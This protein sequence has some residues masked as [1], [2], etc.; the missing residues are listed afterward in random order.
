L[1]LIPMVVEQSNR[2]ERAYDIYSRLLKDNIIFLG[3]PIDD[4]VA[5]VVT[6]QLLFLEAEDPEK[7]IH[8]YINSPG[9]SG[10]ASDIV[11]N[12]LRKAAEKKPVVISMGDVAASGGYWVA[13][14]G[15]EVFVQPTTV[16]GSIG[17]IGAWA[18]DDGIGE[19]LGLTYDFVKAGESADL[20]SWLRLPFVG[21]VVPHRP[22]TDDERARVLAEVGRAYNGFVAKVAKGRKMSE[23]KVESLAKGRVWTGV[24][25]VENGLVDRI[26]G[27]D[28]ALRAARER[29][30]IGE[31]EEV[32]LIDDSIVGLFDVGA[33]TLGFSA[34]RP[35]GSL[36]AP[37][38]FAL[39]R[40]AQDCEELT[41]PCPDAV[42][43]GCNNNACADNDQHGCAARCADRC[44]CERG[45]GGHRDA[46]AA[47]PDARFR[48]SRST[49]DAHDQRH[50]VLERD[51]HSDRGRHGG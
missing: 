27:L 24:Q 7:D 21:G 13:I 38:S 32:E 10:M 41:D 34:E 40:Q 36:I 51:V 2:G 22:M 23:E 35:D 17:V 12:A 37:A 9:G 4:N 19:K 29:A 14:Y 30:G 8:V 11:A 3:T 18:W 50:H 6:A 25:S 28:D 43:W 26:G 1:A 46:A 39:C 44:R 33:A 49:G 45:R 15:D 20:M 42:Q 48:H 47:V 5:N 16:A 31:D